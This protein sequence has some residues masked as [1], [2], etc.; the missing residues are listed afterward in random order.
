MAETERLQNLSKL[1]TICMNM[2]MSK[3]VLLKFVNTVKINVYYS[4]VNI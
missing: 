3:C 1:K 2:F 4:F